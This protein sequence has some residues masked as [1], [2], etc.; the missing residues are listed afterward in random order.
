MNLCFSAEPL[1][2]YNSH[3][4]VAATVF[5]QTRVCI[6]VCNQQLQCLNHGLFRH[7]GKKIHKFNLKIQIKKTTR[8]K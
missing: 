1:L 6:F 8:F 2:N 5:L 4:T 7:F 3:F